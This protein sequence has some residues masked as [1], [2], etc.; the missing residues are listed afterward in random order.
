TI[1]WHGQYVPGDNC[2]ETGCSD[3]AQGVTQE[4]VLT[5]QSFTYDF[6]AKR[7][8]T[9]WYHCHVDPQLHVMEGLYGMMIVDPQDTSHEPK[10]VGGEYDLVMGTV[11]RSVVE[12]IPGLSPH[13]H[14]A[15]CLLSG[16]PDCTNPPV[17]VTADTWLLNGHSY[18]FTE[19]QPQTL[20]KI[21]Q[22][23]TLKLRILNAGTTLEELHIHGHD[24]LVTHKDG[25][26]LLQPYYVDTLPI[27]PAERY[28]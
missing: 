12:A 5:G 25:V 22:G 21:K 9:L 13:A 3:G 4:A 19:M 11:H 24:M 10:D 26:P 1:H 18:P 2:P 7:A 27:G 14:G 15:G 8:G 17:D 6:I 16:K 28:D 20:L 23:E